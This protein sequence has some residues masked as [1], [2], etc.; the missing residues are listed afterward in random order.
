MKGMTGETEPQP[1]LEASVLRK[2]GYEH[3]IDAPVIDGNGITG[4]EF[5]QVYGDSPQRAHTE[6]ELRLFDGMTPDNPG[7][8]L[9][10]TRFS[11]YFTYM[12]EPPQ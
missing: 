9:M 11:R 2:C 8:D 12:F 10:K 7:Y 4:H 3:C 6:E 5:L 1:S